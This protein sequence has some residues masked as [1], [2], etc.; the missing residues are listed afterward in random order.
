METDFEIKDCG[1]VVGFFAK[2]SAALDEMEM[3][4]LAPWQRL[5]GSVFYVDRNL[6]GNLIDA[7]LDN[8]LT[9]S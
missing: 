8:G 4:D 6:A 9:V 7:L 5:G 2:T 1:S 3:M